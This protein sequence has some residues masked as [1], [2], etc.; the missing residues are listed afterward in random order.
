[1]AAAHGGVVVGPVAGVAHGGIMFR[2]AVGHLLY[3]VHLRASGATTWCFLNFLAL[4]WAPICA[5]CPQTGGIG[6][7]G[8]AVPHGGVGFTRHLV[9]VCD[10]AAGG[11]AGSSV[12]ADGLAGT[13]S[14]DGAGMSMA[15]RGAF[16]PLPARPTPPPRAAA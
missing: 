9:P 12:G 3:M 14:R 2:V 4:E 8:D 5:L 16:P 15:D 7:D 1:M 13:G 11:L 10:G 6:E